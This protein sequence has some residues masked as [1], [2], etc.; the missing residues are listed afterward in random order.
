MEVV[1][2]DGA[3]HYEAALADTHTALKLIR[4]GGMI[5]W[6]DYGNYGDYNDVMRAIFALIPRDVVRQVGDTQLAIYVGTRN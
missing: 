5:V 3:H 6:Q 1:Y 4:Y 2:V